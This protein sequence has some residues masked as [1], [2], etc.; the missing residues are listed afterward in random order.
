MEHYR[1]TKVTNQIQITPG[2]FLLK[3]NREFD[4]TPGQVI[5]LTTDKNIPVRLYSIASGMHDQEIAILYT[6]KQ[7]GELTP[8]L[9]K[10]QAGDTI[11]YTPPHGEFIFTAPAWFIATGTGIAPFHSMIQSG[12]KPKKLIQ[13]ARTRNEIYFEQDLNP[14]PNYIKCCSQ[15]SGEGIYKGRLTHYLKALTDFPPAINYYICGS[16]EM[17]VDVRNLLI[18]KGVPFNKII[19][20]I[21]F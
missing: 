12:L 14:L 6:L 9:S 5:G 1:K 4:F 18:S 13:G 3:L 15:D 19:T 16:A 2:A 7:E 11:Y 8:N 10:L 20:E 17:V 21:Y